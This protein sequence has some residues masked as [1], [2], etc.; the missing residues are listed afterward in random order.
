MN[1]ISFNTHFNLFGIEVEFTN[2]LKDSFFKKKIENILKSYPDITYTIPDHMQDHVRSHSHHIVRLSTFFVLNT[3]VHEMGHALALK[4]LYGVNSLVAV[5]SDTFDGLTFCLIDTTQKTPIKETI[6]SLAGPL[7]SIAFSITQMFLSCT[8]K[9]Y[10]KPLTTYLFCSGLFNFLQ[11]T[12]G[13]IFGAT[14]GRGDFG[15]IRKRGA[16]HLIAASAVIA[17]VI[18]LGFFGIMRVTENKKEN[19]QD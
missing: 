12:R 7:A 8:F 10:N 15:N 6:T 16:P 3:F 18:A 13:V 5:R 11:E 9:S 14:S 4:V 2:C 19:E 17:S 1:Y